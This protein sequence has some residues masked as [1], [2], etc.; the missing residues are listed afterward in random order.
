MN[1]IIAQEDANSSTE[2]NCS[3]TPNIGSSGEIGNRSSPYS[4]KSFDRINQTTSSDGSNIRMQ[5][6][7]PV[8][9]PNIPIGYQ[10]HYFPYTIE[11]LIGIVGT[12]NRNINQLNQD[13]QHL[14]TNFC[15]QRIGSVNGDSQGKND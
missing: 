14:K 2:E 3:M 10:L 4:D 7:T 1:N 12:L 5:S 9:D 15:Y 11:R 6:S 13:M 8:Y